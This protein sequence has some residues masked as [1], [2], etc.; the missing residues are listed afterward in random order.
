M[1]SIPLSLPADYWQT[2]QINKKD[3]EF[4]HNHLFESETPMT[5]RE[6]GAV[7]IEERIR[8]ER[9]AQAKKRQSD[10]KVYLPKEN[11]SNGDRLIFPALD[12]ARGAVSAV[13]PGVNPQYGEF[14][15][16]TVELE[17]GQSRMFASGLTEHSLNE[18][19]VANL[20]AETFDPKSI[21]CL[22]N[23]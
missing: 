17:D 15:V 11:Y 3:I 4:L 16:L 21:V 1:A 6:L 12:W 5:A 7:L 2:L 22:R 13:R 8:V 18:E 10:G 14:A 9:A 23:D 20:E 19:P